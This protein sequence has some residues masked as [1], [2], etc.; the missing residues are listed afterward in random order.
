MAK[1]ERLAGSILAEAG[2]GVD[3]RRSTVDRDF[4]CFNSKA[5]AQRPA[6]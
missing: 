2:C 5:G 1:I 3:L 4:T 6:D